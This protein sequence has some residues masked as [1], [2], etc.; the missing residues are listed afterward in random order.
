MDVSK[1]AILSNEPYTEDIE[2]T[3]NPD[4]DRLVL[5]NAPYDAISALCSTSKTVSRICN[6][7]NFWKQKWIQ[8]FGGVSSWRVVLW[9][10]VRSGK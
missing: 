4:T 3:G 2:F 8:D 1:R 5:L 9:T 10:Q 7:D 6:D